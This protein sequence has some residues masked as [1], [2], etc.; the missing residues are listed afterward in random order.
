MQRLNADRETDLERERRTQ[1]ENDDL[2]KQY[3]EAAKSFYGWLTHSRIEILGMGSS[4]KSLDEQLS[5][6]RFKL[7]EIRDAD[8]RFQ[9]V[10]QFGAK[11][12]ERHVY[13]NKYTEHT[14]LSLSQAWNQLE[15][16]SIRIINTL[17]QQLQA[18]SQPG[19]TEDALRDFY[20]MF[21][22]LDRDKQGRISHAD[23]KLCL[24]TLNFELEPDD[25][26]FDPRF[27]HILNQVDP[28]RLGYVALNE[29]MAFLIRKESD[30]VSSTNDVIDAFRALTENGNKPYITKKELFAV[31]FSILLNFVYLESVQLLSLLELI[32]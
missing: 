32:A 27:E 1:I 11:L 7:D 21:N 30:N 13:E 6:A 17:D 20:T 23:F 29:Y 19:V 10:E 2:R 14:R 25:V 5:A 9:P 12:E 16:L 28:Q 3:A 24:I 4:F 15:Q 26:K 18:L 8:I 22:R 31:L